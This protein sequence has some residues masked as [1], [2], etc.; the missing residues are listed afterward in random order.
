MKLRNII[1]KYKVSLDFINK[2][3]QKHKED[4]EQINNLHDKINKLK[5]LLNFHFKAMVTELKYLT[6]IK[7]FKPKFLASLKKLNRHIKETEELVQNNNFDIETKER[8]Y[9]YL[10]LLKNHYNN[11][12]NKLST[13]FLKH[14][15]RHKRKFQLGLSEFN[16]VFRNYGFN[17]S[18]YKYHSQPINDFRKLMRI[19][20]FLKNQRNKKFINFLAMMMHSIYTQNNFEFLPMQISHNCASN[21]L[22]FKTKNYKYHMY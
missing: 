9:L 15:Q 17:P 8:I 19:L 6:K 11:V 3:R 7:L 18:Y 2:M 16:K 4:N 13:L 1:K 20:K 5:K 22:N 12:T 14:Y 21:I 10:N